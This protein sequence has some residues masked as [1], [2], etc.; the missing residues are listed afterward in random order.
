MLLE[1]LAR[2]IRVHDTLWL[3]AAVLLALIGA[4]AFH[5]IGP[6]PAM[7]IGLFVGAALYA[8]HIWGGNA[9]NE[10]MNELIRASAGGLSL[11]TAEALIERLPDPLLLLDA[12]GRVVFSKHRNAWPHR[13]C[14]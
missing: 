14:A 1:S 5:A 12:E 9:L 11:A 8:R 6:W 4:L 3:A 10:G 2:R 13:R 7:F